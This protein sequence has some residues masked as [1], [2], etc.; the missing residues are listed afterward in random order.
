VTASNAPRGLR[1]GGDAAVMGKGEAA[2]MHSKRFLTL[3]KGQPVMQGTLERL[4]ER[5][6]CVFC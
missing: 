3:C 2:V 4:K 5:Y 1:G 6:V